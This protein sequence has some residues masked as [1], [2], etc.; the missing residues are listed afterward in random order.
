MNVAVALSFPLSL[1]FYHSLTLFFR[2]C[3]VNSLLISSVYSIQIFCRLNLFLNSHICKSN[4]FFTS[5]CVDSILLS[6]SGIKTH[7]SLSGWKHVTCFISN[8][9]FVCNWNTHIDTSTPVHRYLWNQPK[10]IWSCFV[11]SRGAS[12]C[13]HHWYRERKNRIDCRAAQQ[14]R[15]KK[16]TSFKHSN[17]KVS[18]H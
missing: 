17:T 11:W 16:N 13:D 1:D 7:G 8:N 4:A 3:T 18:P 6:D 12:A 5:V 15:R 9:L 2:L 14:S 10:P